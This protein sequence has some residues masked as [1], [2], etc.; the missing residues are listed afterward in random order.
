MNIKTVKYR[1]MTK[2][3][4]LFFFGLCFS[5]LL[6]AQKPATI[7]CQI[8]KK[9]GQ[10]IFLYG[11][12]NGRKVIL[13]TAVYQ[14]NG[15]Y[16]FKFL[17][18]YQGFYVI[19]DK[20]NYQYPVYLKSGDA[21]SL[22]IDADTV[23]LTGKKNTPENTILYKWIA[24]SRNIEAKSIRSG[25]TR[26]TYRDFF[27]E[28]EAFLPAAD[29]F[30]QKIKTRNKKFNELLKRSIDYE[31]DFYAIMYLYSARTEHPTREQ[32]PAYYASIINP[33]K[34]RDD[35]VLHMPY[36]MDLL[37]RYTLFVGMEKGLLN[38][39]DKILE[40]IDDVRLKGE[41]V[42]ERATNIHSYF[43]Y[44]SI[45]K[46]YADLL[47]TNQRKRLEDIGAKLYEARKGQ[48]SADF[49]CSD[50]EGKMVSLSDFKG[51]VVMVDVW[52]TW[53]GPCRKELPHLKQLEK[54]MK[55][56]DIV[57]IGVS[58]DET[59]NH[60]KWKQFLKDEQLPGIQLFAG[61]NSKIAKDYK[62]KGIPRF[63]V[64]DRQ[65]K[66]VEANAPRPSDPAL[67]ALLQQELNR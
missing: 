24:L 64:F 38:Q 6:Q 7:E 21:V 27:P 39:W 63:M 19:G 11:V 9:V 58:L 45:L 12:E 48:V 46:Q 37:R 5:F 30:K 34:F 29:R 50:P 28:F 66:V 36:G 59:K 65:G 57:F 2:R 51:K 14:Q 20:Q 18:E 3:N 67:K 40:Q 1:A 54:E 32:R 56:K 62:I 44:K 49:T 35:I 52:A 60:A 4:I 16:G 61:S 26:S 53:C 41:L 31:K 33:D 10:E 55:E 15:Y 43:E 42:V 13:A 23:Y 25:R 8:G 17:P 22:Y 47:N